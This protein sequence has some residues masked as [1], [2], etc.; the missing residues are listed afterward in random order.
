MSIFIADWIGIVLIPNLEKPGAACR[1]NCSHVFCFKSS[2]RAHRPHRST[3]TSGV[4]FPESGREAGFVISREVRLC[5]DPL[6]VRGSP[7]SRSRVAGNQQVCKQTRRLAHCVRRRQVLA[8]VYDDLRKSA[9]LPGPPDG[10]HWRSA[11]H[12]SSSQSNL[13]HASELMTHPRS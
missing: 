4:H 8:T 6:R 10:I 13:V 1:R 3:C 12:L 9:V 5:H 2:L 11:I 7:S